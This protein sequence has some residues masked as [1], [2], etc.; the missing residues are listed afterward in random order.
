VLT[1][2]RA[3]RSDALSSVLRELLSGAPADPFQSDI[4]A[5]PSKGVER[6]IAQ[7]LAASLGARSGQD[8]GV[9]ANVM[10]PSPSR[11]VSEVLVA[12]TGVS[13]NDDPW[14][15]EG[16]PW[17]L[18]NVIDDCAGENWC[19]TLGRHLGLVEGGVNRGRR[20]AV[21]QKFAG[22]FTAYAAE[23]PTMLTDWR[24]G[25]DTD[26][27]GGRIDDDLAWQAE[28]WRRLRQ[29]INAESPAERLYPA[30]ERLREEPDI[31]ELPERVSIFGPTRLTTAQLVVLDALA[32]HRDVHLWLPFPSEGLWRR[33][34]E[35]VST[36][37]TTLQGA[38]STTVGVVSTG[39]TTV[40]VVSTGSTTVG[41]V[42][43]GS[44]TT[45]RDDPTA[46]VPAHPLLRSLGRDAREMH[47]RLH[48]HTT[49]SADEHLPIATS[50]DS[51]L[52]ALQADLRADQT[53]NASH[54]MADGDTTVQ[55][56]AC[57]GRHRQVEVLRE[58]LL[59]LLDDD[60]TLELR[61]II[62]MCPDIDAYAPLIS[63]SLGIEALDDAD[64]PTAAAQVHPGHRLTFRLAD[65][66]LRQ[67]NPV[68]DVVARLLELTD[69]RLTASEVLDLAAMQPVRRRFRFDEEALERVG[70]WVRRVGV[71]WGLD[72]NAR[73]GY[74]L[75]G[76]GQNTWAHGL[77]R[78]LAGVT[79]DEEDLRLVGT[80]L[81]LDDVDSNDIELAGRIAEL[82]DRLEAT[83]DALRQE[84]SIEQWV[85]QLT[86]A[87]DLFTDVAPRDAWQVTQAKATLAGVAALVSTS[88]TSEGSLV[89]TG[90]TSEG[91]LVST[92]ST[93]GEAGALL[94]LSDVR[95]LLGDRLR[96]RP[97]RANFRTGH[98][99]VCT[100]VP[101]RSVPHRVVCLLGLDDGV[102][103]RSTSIDGDD[104]LAR[105]P[106]V[107][108][109]DR[110]SEDRQLFLDAI[111]AAKERLV[112]L[113]TGADERTGAERPPAVPLGELLDVLD[114]TATVPDGRVRDRVLLRHPLQPFDS[115]NFERGE[116]I[117]TET[118]SFDRAS[119]A[120]SLAMRG[121]QSPQ[122]AFLDPPLPAVDDLD[123][124][125][126]ESLIR[127][128]EHPV[129]TFLQERLE[130][131]TADE[132]DEPSDAIPVC[133]SKLEEWAVGDRL[134]RAGLAG[135]PVDGA[136]QVE[137]LRGEL[138]PGQL[139]ATVLQPIADKV[140]AVVEKSAPLRTEE[141]DAIDVSVGL[142]SGPQLEG[143][144]PR[145]Y[146]DRIVRIE[147]SQLS[148][149]HR[150]RAWVQLLA[151]CAG[152][153][154]RPWRAV[155]VGR[156]K[157]GKKEEVV[158]S[159]LAVVPRERAIQLLDQ[160]VS[161]YRL[162]LT[163]PLPVPP[164]TAA[165]Y[166]D[167]RL[168]GCNPSNAKAFAGQEWVVQAQ[169][170]SW[171]EFDDGDHRRVRLQT[172]ND[173]IRQ[174]VDPSEEYADEPHRFGQLARTIWTPML[175]AEDIQ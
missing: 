171:G 103:P 148:A 92:G 3:E 89:S 136:Q 63:A 166:A 4:V 169:Q 51:L 16:L 158:G 118:F 145:V 112:L 15:E 54:A 34:G 126:L 93:S 68:L 101:M 69:S 149:K 10:F 128:L 157:V 46:E 62:V 52:E 84:Q 35:V 38:G 117:P 163:C 113:Y 108:E 150:I 77:D 98:L 155:T 173:L 72:A 22:L 127:F 18:L 96:G 116:L 152:D 143:T 175:D 123:I 23:R 147:Y 37:W 102:F 48:A 132:E 135:Q 140:A 130:L 109:R 55:V 81:P 137:R 30:S 94:A 49:A 124:V 78:L 2:H 144:V 107:G 138:P 162:G 153:P 73:A 47:G 11:L 45:R 53:P 14:A 41:V 29:R 104:I 36:G 129:R 119:Y 44:T 88:S 61:D 71:R 39:S 9:C 24:A 28:L 97:T 7:S 115:R 8:D 12:A 21:A 1:V 131:R 80:A 59:G 134:L 65:R 114:R 70:D 174:P 76:V 121:G 172:M 111:L 82:L 66:S 141:P 156:K 168:K 5:V 13:A 86:E 87:V 125:N 95:A 165:A 139:G 32:A 27:Y 99:T 74:G 75:A 133:P 120:G 57:H 83:V 100:M 40:G 151:L 167:K 17:A 164:K 159:F 161:L 60:P 56:H 79:M 122:H 142:P 110:R 19:R 20:M 64:D 42:S 25:R 6:W 26:G 154:S 160:L 105:Q 106:R 67:T 33:L 90:S 58:V 50:T 170:R 146:A 43:T 31:T 91:P 85:Q